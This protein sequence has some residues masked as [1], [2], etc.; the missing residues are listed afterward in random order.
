MPIGSLF[1][2]PPLVTWL[3][4]REKSSPDPSDLVP[5]MPSGGG[6]HRCEGQRTLAPRVC[7]IKGW[8]HTQLS[9]DPSM[10]HTLP[11]VVPSR[12]DCAPG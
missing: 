2:C 3:R 1:K 12:R 7:G 8:E 9:G 4:L 11:M 6:H 5:W 10:K